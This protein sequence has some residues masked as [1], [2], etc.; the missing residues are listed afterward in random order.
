MKA[1]PDLVNTPTY[2]KASIYDYT[3]F[4]HSRV[5]LE[6]IFIR[7][8]KGYELPAMNNFFEH[9]YKAHICIDREDATK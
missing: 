7:V 4:T 1:F 8:V 9:L 6:P 5:V 2:E 3:R